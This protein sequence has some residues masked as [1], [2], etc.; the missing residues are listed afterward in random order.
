MLPYMKATKADIPEQNGTF[1]H[2][3]R[4]TL[5]GYASRSIGYFCSS[6]VMKR[7]LKRLEEKMRQEMM[8]NERYPKKVQ[9]EKYFMYRNLILAILKAIEN[10]KKSSNVQRAI[11]RAVK[12]VSLDK[13]DRTANFIKKHGRKP[14]AFLVIGPGKF[15]NLKCNGCYANS[16]AAD[17]E[18]IEWDMLDRIMDEK[19]KLWGSYLTVIT[20]GEPLLYESQGKT[21]LDLAKKYSDN[22]FVMFTNGTLIDKTMAKKIQE[23]G[24]ITPAISVEGWE[25]ETDARRGKGT[26]KKIM[27]A[28]ANLREVGVPFGISLTATHANAEVIASDDLVNLYFQENGALYGWIFQLMPIGRAADLGHMVD[29]D[30]R[31]KLLRQTQRLARE[32]NIFLADFW[33]SGCLSDGCISAGR[34]DG[35]LYIDWNGSVTPCV[36]NPYS[37]VNINDIYKKGGNLNDILDEPFFE[38]IRRWQKEYALDRKP[39]EMGNWL[40]PCPIKDHYKE[41]KKMIEKHKPQPTDE[42]SRLAM[43]D[44]EYEKRLVEYGEKVAAASDPI[45]KKEYLE[46]K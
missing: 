36:F 7:I 39:S 4:K 18:K 6:F 5:D 31:I 11:I 8:R 10:A 42:A 21:L 13:K 27:Q 17:S 15:C 28:M 33:N 30:Q 3:F 25:K 22:Y 26:H 19:E 16:S 12:N 20:G 46:E 1:R 14:P 37:P 32:K 40:I 9:E 45:W 41:M 2:M 23:A 43:T 24:N 35:Y 34:P 44:K 29:A 38:S